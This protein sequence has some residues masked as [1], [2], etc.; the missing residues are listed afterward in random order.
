[1]AITTDSI[2]PV[3]YIIPSAIYKTIY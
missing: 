1:M 3:Q 2:P